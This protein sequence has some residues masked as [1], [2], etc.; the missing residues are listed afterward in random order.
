MLSFHRDI[1]LTFANGHFITATKLNKRPD[2]HTEIGTDVGL[3]AQ[4]CDV[5]EIFYDSFRVGI[6]EHDSTV[7]A[8]ADIRLLHV[9]H[10]HSNSESAET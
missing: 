6:L 10:I 9:S 5:R 3:F 7:L 2:K 8:T 4:V 1:S